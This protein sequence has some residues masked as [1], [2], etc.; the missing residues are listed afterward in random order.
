MD[1]KHF[2]NFSV[3]GSAG[4]VAK[5]LLSI[6][7]KSA[8]DKNDP[9]NTFISTTRF[10]LIDNKQRGME[11]Y[12]NSF[13]NL[14]NNLITYNFDLKKLDLLKKHLIQTKT[15]LVIDCSFADT[16]ETLRLCN[17]LN[18]NY[19]NTAFENTMI[20][21][22]ESYEGF[23][24]IERYN[25]FERNKSNFKNSTAII[26]SG[27]NPGIVQ[28]MALELL[29]KNPEEKPLGCYIV[30]QDDSFYADKSLA[31]KETVY[32]TWSPECFLDEAILGYPM[33][34]KHRT[35]LFLYQ[36]VYDIEFK[37]SLGNI[38]FNGCLMA[39]EEVITLG[40]LFD[41]ETGFIYRVNDHTTKLI[42]ANLDHVDDLWDWD[43]EVLDPAKEE[44]VGEDL[45]GVLLVYKDKE[46]FM[47]NV[48]SNQEVFNKFK[49]NATYFQV[50][51]G[52][53][54]AIATLLLDNLPQGVYYVDE[55]LLNTNTN[56]DKYLRYY[57]T[58][59]VVG[60]NNTSQGTLLERMDV[61]N[62]F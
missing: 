41:M 19:I 11:Y 23:G 51:C 21:E 38:K 18:I 31:K 4:G 9:I 16:V 32:T 48:L 45:V 52:I 27:M 3:L 46:R 47:Y 59:F 17:E 57:L 10:H 35:P 2:N 33:F 25:I 8:E 24:L 53:Y 40:K 20:D 61:P 54:G 5:A 58:D 62:D 37:V 14:F 12:Q 7:N 55:L 36:N 22:D 26:G 49:I 1:N 29:K 28:W 44:I 56:Y 34:V 30:E 6:L 43:M 15:T 42:R 50:A 39:H 60:E 13:P